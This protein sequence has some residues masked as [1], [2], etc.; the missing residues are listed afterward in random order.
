MLI[1]VGFDTDINIDYANFE[2]FIVESDA[3]EEQ[4]VSPTNP[5]VMNIYRNKPTL[6]HQGESSEFD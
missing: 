1:E 5:K 4:T 2:K 3:N 6:E